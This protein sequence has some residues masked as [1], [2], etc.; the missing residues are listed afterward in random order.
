MPAAS[1]GL[2]RLASAGLVCDPANG[3]EAQVDRGGRIATLLKVHAIAQDHRAVKREP[4][5]EQYQLT[6]SRIAWSSVRGPLAEVR[7]WSTDVLACS[8]G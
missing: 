4:S 2:R 8:I 3:C 7:L 5:S 1:S 6:N